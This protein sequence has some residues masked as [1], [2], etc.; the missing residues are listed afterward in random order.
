MI[1]YKTHFFFEMELIYEPLLALCS[2]CVGFVKVTQ[3]LGSGVSAPG[4]VLITGCVDRVEDGPDHR[5]G[6]NLSWLSQLLGDLKLHIKL[7]RH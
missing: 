5:A 7:L 4:M 6:N 1:V 2:I 3:P